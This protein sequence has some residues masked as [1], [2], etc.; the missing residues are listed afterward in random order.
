MET[1]LLYTFL[2]ITMAIRTAVLRPI[3][4]I[5]GN[6]TRLQWLIARQGVDLI[7]TDHSH[8]VHTMYA[9]LMQALFH[10]DEGWVRISPENEEVVIVVAMMENVH[11][12]LERQR[13][14]RSSMM[15]SQ[16]FARK[17]AT[18]PW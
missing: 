14:P 16:S 17:R 11:R 18:P 1:K 6:I 13:D 4:S 7:L 5:P 2:N 12:I 15:L 10:D 8:A 9:K 3:F